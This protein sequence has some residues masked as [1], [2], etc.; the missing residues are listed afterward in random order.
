MLAAGARVE[1]PGVLLGV[2]GA[3]CDGELRPAEV[4]DRVAALAAGGAWA[5]T[6][7]VSPAAAARIERA[8]AEAVTEASL[9]VARA[10]RG[11]TGAV[12]IRGGRRTVELTPVA[13]LCF[14][15]DLGLAR[16][17][18]PLAEAVAGAGSIA[19]A[20]ERL[21]ALGVGTELDY[22]RSRPAAG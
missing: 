2:L 1:G 5:G 8:A 7:G 19:A 14:A 4:L 21:R 22:E 17:A 12:P 16:G 20:N 11:E 15:F 13:A 9:L 18:L 6:I 3:G 10:A